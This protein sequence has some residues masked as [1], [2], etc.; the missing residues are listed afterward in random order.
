MEPRIRV[1][2]HRGEPH[3]SSP[4]TP[5]DMRV[6]IRRFGWIELCCGRAGFSDTR[7]A[8]NVSDP[9]QGAVGASLRPSPSKASRSWLFC[10]LPL[11]ES[12]RLLAASFRLGLRRSRAYYARCCLLPHDRSGSL[13]P[14]SRF[15]DMQQTSRDKNNRLQRAS[16]GF[17]TS[18]LD[19]YA[20]RGHLPARP[21]P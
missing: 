6:R 3:G 9:P 15:R 12:R 7:F 20:L 11:I 1:N 13:H 18:A 5:P 16:A 19:G 14:Q 4:A 21:A 8:V 10:R 17:T 2:R